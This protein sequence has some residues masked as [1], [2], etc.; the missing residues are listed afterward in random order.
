MFKKIAF[1][2]AEVLIV[3]GIIG[4]IAEMT[5]PTL[6]KNT[7][8]L[9]F[10]AAF[11]KNYSVLSSAYKQILS[12]ENLDKLYYGRYAAS[13]DLRAA[14]LPYLKYVRTCDVL[15]SK[16]DCWNNIGAR[17][18][19]TSIIYGDDTWWWTGDSKVT[20][21]LVDGTSLYFDVSPVYSTCDNSQASYKEC[22]RIYVDVNGLNEPNTFG[23]DIYILYIFQDKIGPPDASIRN[24]GTLNVG[25]F[26]AQNVLNANDG[27]LE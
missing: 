23:R 7:Q 1:T 16:G 18:Y 17:S 10:T 12:A 5:I 4:M 26:R 22:G 8:D 13:S 27:G 2:L 14:F 19:T 25:W 3:I 6:V 15:A 11:K 9:Q 21:V 20:A 24:A